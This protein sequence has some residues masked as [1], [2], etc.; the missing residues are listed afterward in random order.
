[1][2]EWGVAGVIIALVGLLATVVP[3]IIKLNSSIIKLP[4]AVANT[5]AKGWIGSEQYQEIIAEQ[6]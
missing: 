6:K 3:P 4:D 1:M 2:T 5:V